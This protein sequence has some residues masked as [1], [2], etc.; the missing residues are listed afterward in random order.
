MC[1]E[2][3]KT[4]LDFIYE[5]SSVKKN[6]NSYIKGV[7]TLLEKYF[8]IRNTL[9]FYYALDSITYLPHACVP[10]ELP[11]ES[12]ELDSQSMDS[13]QANLTDKAIEKAFLTA[14][15]NNL[16]RFNYA[17]ISRLPDEHQY[18]FIISDYEFDPSF[19]N[20]ISLE[21]YVSSTQ[22]K[23][24]SVLPIYI[25]NALAGVVYILKNDDDPIDHIDYM[26]ILSDCSRYIK[27][28]MKEIVLYTESVFS[29]NIYNNLNLYSPIANIIINCYL[30]VIFA[31]STAEDFC[32]EIVDYLVMSDSTLTVPPEQNAIDFIVSHIYGN[33]LPANANSTNT[34]DINNASYTF[35]IVSFISTSISGKLQTYYMIYIMKVDNQSTVSLKYIADKFNLTSREVDIVQLIEQGYKNSDIADSLFISRNTVKAHISNIFRKMNVQ[36]R[37]ALVHKLQSSKKAL[38]RN[39]L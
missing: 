24:F 20:E 37:T 28:G 21:S 18:D 27:A 36:T 29:R 4:L 9:F 15:K 5:L 2:Y 6:Y 35:S 22:Y 33:S 8:G 11:K 26:A 19:K 13:I 25:K 23:S 31:N 14:H 32:N 12:L 17:V 34:L 39:Q 38:N 3:T 16:L 1:K 30:N 10:Y 7:L